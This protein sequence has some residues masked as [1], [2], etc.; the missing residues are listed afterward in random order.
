[1]PLEEKTEE[2]T[3]Q[4]KRDTRE[5]GQVAK[6][7]ELSAG[8]AMLATLVSLRYVFPG[9]LEGFR[10]LFEVAV[11][12]W[13]ARELSIETA[14]AIGRETTLRGLMIV[15]PVMLV[16]MGTAA[17]VTFAQ[18]GFLFSTKALA[19]QFSRLDPFK[20]MQR[21][22]S[23]KAAVELLRSSFKVTILGYVVWMTLR[24]AAPH[25]A[26]LMN[27]P[28]LEVVRG[29]G[30]VAWTLIMRA[31]MAIIVIATFDF[32]W[33]RKQHHK[34]M[35]MTRQE[36]KEDF[37]RSE[38]D[39]TTRSRVRAIMREMSSR[40]MMA[41][42]PKADVIVTNPIR[43][44]VALQYDPETMQAPVVLAKG[45]RLVAEKIRQ[46]A[47]EHDIPI[48]RNVPLA[49]SLFKSVDIG[50]AVPTEL[51]TA[52]AEVLAAVYRMKG[53]TI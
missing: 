34:E 36:V 43:L 47:L 50:E 14:S 33:Q 40:R 11:T 18:V 3:E 20:G 46:I 45:Q 15:L 12:Q 27:A 49:R 48:M 31:S 42:V 4:R 32:F 1:M 2:P 26:S 19:P 24:D 21:L 6:S 30:Q 7:M 9:I 17:L 28:L 5:K 37:K 29:L 35:M 41:D 25:L 23:R 13:P 10:G 39:P 53:K 51:Y 38:G 44:A 16:A 52:V 22:F 8:I